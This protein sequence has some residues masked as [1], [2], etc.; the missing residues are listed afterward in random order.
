MKSEM[1]FIFVIIMVRRPAVVNRR[2][3]EE[4]NMTR[5]FGKALKKSF[6]SGTFY[7]LGI[8]LITIN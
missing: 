1:N 6:E 4:E 3:L 2:K 7:G 8:Y 5:P